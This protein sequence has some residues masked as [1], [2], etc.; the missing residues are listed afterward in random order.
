MCE[1]KSPKHLLTIFR[2]WILCNIFLKDFSRTWT[3]SNV[4]NL[5]TMFGL[6]HGFVFVFPNPACSR[7]Q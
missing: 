4:Y 1:S 6:K 3:K 7:C 2:L 5:L